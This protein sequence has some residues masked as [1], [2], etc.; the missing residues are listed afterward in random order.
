MRFI[1]C[2]LISL[3]LCINQQGF[4]VKILFFPGKVSEPTALEKILD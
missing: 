4:V 1:D 2:Q 3:G